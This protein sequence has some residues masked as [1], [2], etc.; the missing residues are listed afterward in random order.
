M[1]PRRRRVLRCGTVLAL[2]FTRAA[3]AA[4]RAFDLRIVRRK[5]EPSA[6]TLRVTAGDQVEL[7]WT[8]DEA[9][10]VHLHGYDIE[11]ALDPAAERRMRFE[12]NATG[13]YPIGAHGFGSDSGKGSHREFVLLYLEVLPR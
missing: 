5:I 12:A 2:A 1:N 13:R 10:T 7:R 8:T 6:G 11:L 9:T 3:P 4:E